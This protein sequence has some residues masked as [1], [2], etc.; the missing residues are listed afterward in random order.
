MPPDFL[1]IAASEPLTQAAKTRGVPLVK[2]VGDIQKHLRELFLESSS[3]VF[4][5]LRKRASL[6]R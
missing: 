1:A 2:A 6:I 3:L 4:N 5:L